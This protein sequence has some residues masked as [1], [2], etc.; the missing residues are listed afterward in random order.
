MFSS[1]NTSGY[2]HNACGRLRITGRCR[3]L[4]IQALKAR[5]VLFYNF[6]FGFGSW[7]FST[8]WQAQYVFMRPETTVQQKISAI[9]NPTFRHSAA[10]SEIKGGTP[11]AF[12]GFGTREFEL[13]LSTIKHKSAESSHKMLPIMNYQDRDGKLFARF[14]Y[15]PV[16]SRQYVPCRPSV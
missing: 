11:R 7:A 4:Q 3:D 2:G 1:R 6:A 9:Q 12:F 15:M 5:R 8:P 10:I 14:F 16:I 13:L